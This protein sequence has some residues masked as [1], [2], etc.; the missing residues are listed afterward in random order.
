[1]TA[2]I[3]RAPRP[4]IG[5]LRLKQSYQTT[6]THAMVVAVVLHFA[7]VGVAQLTINQLT[8]G[9]IVFA[10]SPTLLRYHSPFQSGLTE[11][12]TEEMSPTY[13]L[14]PAQ[15]FLRAHPLYTEIALLLNGPTILPHDRYTNW[16]AYVCCQGAPDTVSRP[17]RTPPPWNRRPEPDYL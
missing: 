1:M 11:T 7:I 15:R 6:L 8:E 14:T 5:N 9:E 4:H 13:A 12:M 16:C 17:S 10:I 2:L 3:L